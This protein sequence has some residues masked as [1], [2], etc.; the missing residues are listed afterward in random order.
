MKRPA[1][2]AGL[3]LILPLLPQLSLAETGM[4]DD[5]IIRKGHYPA[6]EQSIALT[7]CHY[8]R[9][10]SGWPTIEAVYVPYPWGGDTV[11][12]VLPD[13]RSTEADATWVNACADRKLGR[14]SQP[15]PVE[16][17]SSSC[18]RGASVLYGGAGYCVG[19]RY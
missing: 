3:F 1:K 4:T 12:R 18:P 2:V 16:G 8:E 14:N 19:R 9:G 5:G 11:M 7:D 15:Q 10:L 6:N 17:S 13:Q